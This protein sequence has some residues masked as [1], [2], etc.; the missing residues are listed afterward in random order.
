[1]QV[2]ANTGRNIQ[3]LWLEV[4]ARK[5]PGM[6]A[7]HIFVNWVGTLRCQYL[8]QPDFTKIRARKHNKCE[9]CRFYTMDS[10]GRLELTYYEGGRDPILNYPRMRFE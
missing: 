1:M 4:G 7:C 8:T 2:T 6:G 10:R 9:P 5:E 3:T